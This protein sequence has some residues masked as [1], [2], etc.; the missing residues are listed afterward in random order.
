MPIKQKKAEKGFTLIELLVVMAIIAVLAGA[1]LVSLSGQKQRAQEG[2]ALAEMS[3]VIQP[4]LMCKSDGHIVNG[5]SSG[6]AIC[7]DGANDLPAYKYWPNFG[8]GTSLDNITNSGAS[9]DLNNSPW[10]FF[11]ED[12][13]VK[14]CCN[15]KSSRCAQIKSSDTCDVNTDLT[16]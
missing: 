13:K 7:N 1:I 15:S 3:S 14:I 8:S 10:Y 6:G 16:N 4:L 12:S 9:A 2:R 5:F 11:L